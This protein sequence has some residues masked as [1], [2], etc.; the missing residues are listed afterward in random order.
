LRLPDIIATRN[1]S[2]IP[3]SW[4]RSLFFHARKVDAG[5]SE[6]ESILKLQ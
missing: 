2:L 5:H 4:L 3:Q 1:C 6:T